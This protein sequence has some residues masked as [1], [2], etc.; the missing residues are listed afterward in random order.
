MEERE[1]LVGNED[2]DYIFLSE[3]KAPLSLQL[4]NHT[5]NKHRTNAGIEKKVN[6]TTLRNTYAMKMFNSGMGVEE[7][8]RLLGH[9]TINFTSTFYSEYVSRQKG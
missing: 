8:S 2:N 3:R 5:L 4:T 9:T 7:L 6:N 1:K